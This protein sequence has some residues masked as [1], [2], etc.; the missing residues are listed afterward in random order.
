MR[1]G[2]IVYGKVEL[3]MAVHSDDIVIAGSDETCRDFHDALTAAM[4]TNYLGE[5][6]WYTGYAFKR[7]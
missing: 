5:L 1:F 6:I 3:S 7:N 2:I 4:P